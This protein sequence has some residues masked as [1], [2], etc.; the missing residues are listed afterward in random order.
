MRTQAFAALA[1]FFRER[2]EGLGSNFRECGEAKSGDNNLVSKRGNLGHMFQYINP[3]NK[4]F[5]CSVFPRR[6]ERQSRC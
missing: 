4:A 2:G 3:F 6:S 1:K 5:V